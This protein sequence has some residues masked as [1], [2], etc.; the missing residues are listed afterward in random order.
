MAHAVRM[1]KPGQA[2]EEC[3]IVAWYKAEGDA[4]HRGDALFEIETDKANMDVESF[5]DGILLR[6]VVAEGE[7]VPVNTICAWIGAAGEEIP[8][9]VAPEPEFLGHPPEVE[10]AVPVAA[11]QAGVVEPERPPTPIAS[12]ADAGAPAGLRPGQS[13]R[14]EPLRISPRASRMAA[15]AGIDPRTLAGTGPGGR[16]VERD[17]Q[18]AVAR[19]AAP[20][21]TPIPSTPVPGPAPAMVRAESAE[22]PP[23]AAEEEPRPL[24]RMRR[25]I[26]E[27]LTRSW[28][29]IPAFTVTVAVDVTGLLAFRAEL[30]SA[31]V[32]LTLTDFVLAAAAQSLAEFPDVNSR[33][34][35]QV[36]WVRHRVH[37]GVAVSLPEGLVVAVI[38]DADRLSTVELHDRAAQLVAAA[39]E[40]TLNVDDMRGST[41]TVS[42]LGMFGVEQ[43]GA[44]INP[45]DSAILAVSSAVPTPVALGQAMESGISVRTIMRL[46][47]TA[48]HRIVDGEMGA[49]FVNAIRRR[50]EDV[51]SY[52]SEFANS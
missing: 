12:N 24:S 7:T 39:R 52:R 33:T 5:E 38:R 23:L 2:T 43:F 25:V 9:A 50:L 34:D 17:V 37:L 49:R 40:G 18:A 14:P 21:A 15:E 44:I 47:L 13:A 29:T 10:S 32:N 26:A 20:A 19:I 42:N 6:R 28:Q 46:T 30:K 31:G 4:I 27:R 45:G 16:I 48:D 51:A 8:D 1:P 3:T 35:G 22:M 36:V 41:F 11:D